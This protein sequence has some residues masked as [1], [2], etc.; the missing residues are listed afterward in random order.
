MSPDTDHFAVLVTLDFLRHVTEITKMSNFCSYN[1]RENAK[2]PCGFMSV[3]AGIS[4][5]D[6]VH[7]LNTRNIM[8][9]E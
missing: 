4:R 6:T 1:G 5:V 2:I 8:K 7:T 9:C 3:N